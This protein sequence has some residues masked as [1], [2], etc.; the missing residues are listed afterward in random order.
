MNRTWTL[1][2]VCTPVL[3][4]TYVIARGVIGEIMRLEGILSAWT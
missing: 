2:K 4:M 1:I 3:E